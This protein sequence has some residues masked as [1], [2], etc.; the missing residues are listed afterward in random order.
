MVNRKDFPRQLSRTKKDLPRGNHDY[1]C[2]NGVSAVVWCDRMPI[3]FVST[4]H[5]PTET[6][7]V[8][9]RNK[10]G[11]VTDI[12]C[13]ILVKDYNAYM[14]GCDLNDQQTKLYRTRKHYRWPRRLMVKCLMWCCYNAFVIRRHITPANSITKRKSSFSSFLDE[15]CSELIGDVRSGTPGRRR[16]T[17]SSSVTRLQRN[18]DHFPERPAEA[19]SNNRCVVCQRKK[20]WF[21]KH[22]PGR[23][24]PH[25]ENKT[26]Y[27]CAACLVFLCI[28]PGCKCWFDYHQKVE[29]WR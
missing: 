4:I 16:A 6:S 11:S 24:N 10:D 12:T 19:T 5:D 25:K 14:G 21:A 3:Y 23:K 27:R 29:Y 28:R 26:V 18:E 7:S 13:P 22:T 8:P 17:A 9:R 20:N 15:L 1:L 2:K